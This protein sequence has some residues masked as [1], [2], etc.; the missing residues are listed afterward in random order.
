MS[1]NK[2]SNREQLSILA[3][4]YYAFINTYAFT[5]LNVDYDDDDPINFAKIDEKLKNQLYESDIDFIQDIKSILK[6]FF[7]KSFKDAQLIETVR[8]FFN[9]VIQDQN[10][11]I[12]KLG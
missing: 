12:P 6:L 10:K 7:D 2:I 5:E 3:Q 8:L 9:S 11:H 1:L 4:H